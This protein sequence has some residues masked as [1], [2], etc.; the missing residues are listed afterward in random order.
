MLIF[1]SKAYVAIDMN[2]PPPHTHVL[3]KKCVLPQT[4]PQEHT[5]FMGAPLPISPHGIGRPK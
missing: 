5:Y 4:H 2:T 1:F 3:K